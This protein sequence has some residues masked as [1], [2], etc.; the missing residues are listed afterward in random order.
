[1]TPAVH[2]NEGQERRSGRLV[3]GLGQPGANSQRQ[4]GSQAALLASW[5]RLGQAGRVRVAVCVDMFDCSES[6][7]RRRLSSDECRGQREE[8]RRR[9][10]EHRVCEHEAKENRGRRRCSVPPRRQA[11]KDPGSSAAIHTRHCALRLQSGGLPQSAKHCF[12]P[13][14]I[15][16]LFPSRLNLPGANSGFSQV[17]FKTR[18]TALTLLLRLDLS[19]PLPSPLALTITHYHRA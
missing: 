11:A 6:S 9:E 3:R 17:C 1:M 4:P 15:K 5:R 12:S 7:L 14:W 16:R 13:R 18:N 8:T 19:S 2:D 10:T